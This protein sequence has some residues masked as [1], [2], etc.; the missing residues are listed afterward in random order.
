VSDI[1]SDTGL[2]AVLGCATPRLRLQRALSKEPQVPP[3]RRRQDAVEV[4]DFGANHIQAEVDLSRKGPAWL[5]YADALHPGWKASVDGVPVG[6]TAAYGAFKAVPLA[7]GRVHQVEMWFAPVPGT[8]LSHL[9]VALG[10]LLFAAVVVV[11]FRR[12]PPIRTRSRFLGG[13]PPVFD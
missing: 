4:V 10:C 11:S 5:V 3:S 6:I 7:G 12:E 8:L 1:T 13:E 9:F 2:R